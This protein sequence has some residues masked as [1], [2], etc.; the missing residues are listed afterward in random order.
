MGHCVCSIGVD[1]SG[2]PSV[3]SRKTDQSFSYSLRLVLVGDKVLC[4]ASLA[5]FVLYV[6]PLPGPCE[7]KMPRH[8]KVGGN[9]SDIVHRGGLQEG[10]VGHDCCLFRHQEPLSNIN[11]RQS[12]VRAH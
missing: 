11:T 8:P 7:E 9:S 3:F 2:I 6:Q 5:L 1:P 4:A 10:V 12:T